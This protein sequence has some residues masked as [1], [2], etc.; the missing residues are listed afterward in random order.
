MRGSVT[1]PEA[2]MPI[3]IDFVFFW[4]EASGLRLVARCVKYAVASYMTLVMGGLAL[5]ATLNGLAL[6]VNVVLVPT[7]S[8]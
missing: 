2:S 4:L 5:A 8:R 3:P 6:F 1:G 7:V